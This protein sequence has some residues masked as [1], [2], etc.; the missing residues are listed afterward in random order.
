MTQV[1][2]DSYVQ[3]RKLPF[4][5]RLADSR[6]DHEGRNGCRPTRQRVAYPYSESGRKARTPAQ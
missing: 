6:R 5:L 3:T 4:K 1:L 2:S